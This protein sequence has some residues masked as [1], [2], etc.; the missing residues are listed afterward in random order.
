MKHAI[1]FLAVAACVDHRDGVTGTQSIAVELVAP[2]DPGTIDDRLPD[3]ARTVTMNLTAMDA[4]NNMD[5]TYT[6]DL[7]VF[8]NFL[9]TLT[10]PLGALQ[11]LATF[12]VENGVAMNQTVMLPPVFGQATV[13][14][15]DDQ[16]DN[17]TYATGTSPTL[18]FRDPVISDVQTPH[19]ETALD[20]LQA[21]PLQ[22]KNIDVSAS[23]Y[24]ANGRLV[25]TSI[26]AQGYTVQDMNCSNAAGDPPCTTDPYDSIEIF[27]YSAP[28]DQHSLLLAEGECITGFR[29]GVSE[30]NGLTEVGFPESFTDDQTVNTMR[31]PPPVKLDPTTWFQPLS[32]PDG[33]IN[34]ER[35]EAA[36]IE[37]DNGVM[38]ALD[39]DYTTYKQWKIAPGGDCSATKQLINIITAGVIADLD[40]T[41]I[42]TG[43]VLPKVVGILRPVSIGSFNVWIIY[44]RRDADLTL[45]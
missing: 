6:A 42:P 39:D 43:A 14:M 34:F 17:A 22:N 15:S 8:V 41:T 24:G 4:D 26:F 38:C 33:E 16:D 25:V 29:G 7:Q 28:E 37:I 18:W 9:G 10:P 3:T 20:A 45:Q 2:T 27:S 11:P 36:A 30:F 21:S 12:H 35:W 31:E 32:N 19:S 1:L 5:P 23:R 40:P 44:P 13:W